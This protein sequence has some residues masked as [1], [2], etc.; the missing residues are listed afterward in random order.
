MSSFYFEYFQTET[1][2]LKIFM[3]LIITSCLIKLFILVYREFKQKGFV[4][5]SDSIHLAT[6]MGNVS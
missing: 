2:L 3:N 1:T 4:M 5:D 6:I